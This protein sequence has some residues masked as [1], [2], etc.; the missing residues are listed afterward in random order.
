MTLALNLEKCL[1]RVKLP[2][3]LRWN[4]SGLNFRKMFGQSKITNAS[5]LVILSR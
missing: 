2:T 3:L 5:A 1:A 4:D